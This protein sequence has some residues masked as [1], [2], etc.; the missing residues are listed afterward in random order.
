[1]RL[2]A[3]AVTLLALA[4]AITPSGPTP[5]LYDGLGFPDQPYRY[6]DAPAGYQ[7]TPAPG[8]AAQDVP[9]RTGGSSTYDAVSAELGPQAEVFLNQES[10]RPPAGATVAHVRAA[11]VAASSQPSD[12]EVWGNVYRLSVATDTG[13]A[14][15]APGGRLDSIRLRAPTGPPPTARIEFRDRSGWHRLTTSK[16]GN[17]IYS[18]PL[19][20]VGDYAVIAPP[21]QGTVPHQTPAPPTG[22]SS[23]ATGASGGEAATPTTSPTYTR[24][25]L[26][27]LGAALLALIAVVAAIRFGRGRSSG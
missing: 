15:V 9:I 20:G 14:T 27:I 13:P 6:V 4:W 11:P 26:V 16:I 3:L 1:M 8:P 17:D 5:P 10:V 2:S 21:G 12:G 19:A 22:P 7:H 25:L 24:P 18:A 23:A